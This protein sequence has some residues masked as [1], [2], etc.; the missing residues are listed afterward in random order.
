[1][2]HA[3]EAFRDLPLVGC[4][5]TVCNILQSSVDNEINLL[6]DFLGLFV[7][8]KSQICCSCPEFLEGAFQIGIW[9]TSDEKFEF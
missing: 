1:M 6:A 9:A 7:T 5:E 2:I 3:L 4:S 8:V